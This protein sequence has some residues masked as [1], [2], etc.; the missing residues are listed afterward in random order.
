MAGWLVYRL[1]P[2]VAVT[3]ASRTCRASRKN[4]NKLLHRCFSKV[5]KM[6]R[7]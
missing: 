2:S 1:L 6:K 7:V 4:V 3:C 5:A